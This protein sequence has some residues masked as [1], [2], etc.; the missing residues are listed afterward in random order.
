M[1]VQVDASSALRVLKRVADEAG[2]VARRIV[3]DLS[4]AGEFKAKTAAQATSPTLAGSI[5]QTPISESTDGAEGGFG[6][7]MDYAAF[8]EYGTGRPGS[9][10]LVKNGELR[11]P[12]AAGY[13]YTLETVI[14]SGPRQGEIR[15]GWVFWDDVRQTFVH[16]YGQ[17]AGP[18]MYP[19]KLAVEQIAGDTAAV[20]VEESIGR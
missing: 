6:T 10:G 15:E 16:T 11:N 13:A 12:A 5:R 17:P 19:A 4:A 3:A 1:K 2:S 8:V 9:K 20:T 18:F 7:N 14:A